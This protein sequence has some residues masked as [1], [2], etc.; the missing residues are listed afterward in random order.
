[1]NARATLLALGLLIATAAARAD[2]PAR[3]GLPPKGQCSFGA[4]VA[5]TGPAGLNVRAG[6]SARAAVVGRLPPPVFDSELERP[7]AMSFQVVESRD[8]WFRIT[9]AAPPDGS[10]T[11]EPL[12]SGWISGRYVDFSIQTD[13]A[14][15]EPD[16]SSAVVASAWR[17][18]DGGHQI[19]YRRPSGCRGEWVRLLVAGRDGRERQGWLRGICDNQETTC[20]GV[21]GDLLDYDKMPAY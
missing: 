13:L 14:F 21:A 17:D 18:E 7:M 20:D 15:A 1:M 6:P 16:P 10:V 5:D 2:G 12:P 4:W 19:S 3:T 8:G 9:D 11:A